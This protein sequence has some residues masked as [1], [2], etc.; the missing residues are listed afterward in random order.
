MELVA[1]SH[2]VSISI[3]GTLAGTAV[4]V[5]A[6]QFAALGSPKVEEFTSAITV[7]DT[8]T[9]FAAVFNAQVIEGMVQHLDHVKQQDASAKL[10]TI[11]A[12]LTNANPREAGLFASLTEQAEAAGIT[13]PAMNV[14]MASNLSP[15]SLEGLSVVEAVAVMAASNSPSLDRFRLLIRLKRYS[16]MPIYS[17]AAVF[18]MGCRRTA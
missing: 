2:V 12:N 15:E 13:I 18:S 16:T 14:A 8:A 10:P 17:K 11:S 5:N 7:N 1:D 6:S 3:A 4:T 9:A